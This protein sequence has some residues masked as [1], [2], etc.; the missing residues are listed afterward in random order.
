MFVKALQIFLQY[1]SL[2][3]KLRKI[4]KSLNRWNFHLLSHP[5][6]DFHCF[7]LSRVDIRNPLVEI[8]QSRHGI[9]SILNSFFSIINSNK[10]Q[11]LFSSTIGTPLDYLN[12]LIGDSFSMAS[13]S[14]CSS[15]SINFSDASSP[16]MIR[17]ALTINV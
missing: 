1:D 15:I 2:L 3:S 8:N 16:F 10:I 13:S 11:R 17:L 7:H 14:I 12:N 6:Q 9:N 4:I 5:H